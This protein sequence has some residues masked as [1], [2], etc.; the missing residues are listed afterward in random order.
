MDKKTKKIAKIFA[1][2]LPPVFVVL[3]KIFYNTPGKIK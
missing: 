2:S 3:K 1:A